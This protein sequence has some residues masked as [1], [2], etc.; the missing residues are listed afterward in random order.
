MTF[1]CWLS[2]W[3]TLVLSSKISLSN[4]EVCLKCVLTAFVHCHCILRYIL[5]IT[6]SN[7]AT[8]K[9]CMKLKFPFKYLIEQK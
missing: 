9:T 8:K 2:A 7:D 4:L 3:M 5:V 1:C 6:Y